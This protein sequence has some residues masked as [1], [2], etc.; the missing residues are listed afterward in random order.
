MLLEA[1]GL[2]V[3]R[4]QRVVL[5][6]VNLAITAGECV[7]VVGPNGA[8]KSTLME[9][10]LGLLPVESG[11]VKLDS[12]HLE[13]LPRREIARRIAYVPQ[14]HDGYLG[15]SIRDVVEG[16]RYAYRQPLEAYDREDRQAI[17]H[18]MKACRIEELMDRRMDTLSGGERQKAWIAAA[19]AQQ[20][21]ML[22]LDEPTTALDPAHQ[23]DLIRIMRDCA[24]SGRTL[25]VI[26][27]DLNLPLA[28]GGRVI[29]LRD[30]RVVFDGS[31]EFLLDKS[32][33]DGLFGTRFA[34]HRAEEGSA[35]SIQLDV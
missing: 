30:R 6:E 32:R 9:A 2:T 16:G 17:D 35:R 26:C 31:V 13:N 24:H 11:V 18:A 22:F 34:L 12:T 20:T 15:Y 27:H 7:T 29:G 3:R 25:L 4:G 19:L 14:Q 28:L 33:I 21:P 5:N 10:M 8:G 1:R 23:A